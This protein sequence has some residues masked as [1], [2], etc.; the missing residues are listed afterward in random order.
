[1][2][3]KAEGVH[4]GTLK[5]ELTSSMRRT[6]ILYIEAYEVFLAYAFLYSLVDDCSKMSRIFLKFA[7]LSERK[8][9]FR[10]FKTIFSIQKSKMLR[11]LNLLA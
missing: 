3:M 11:F 9:A 6:L 8:N 1:M 10:Y 4:F 7:D 2:K 5:I